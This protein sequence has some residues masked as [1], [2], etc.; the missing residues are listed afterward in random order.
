VTG[1]DDDIV[2]HF[3]VEE[4]GKRHALAAEGPLT[5]CWPLTATVID[6][7]GNE[8]QITINPDGSVQ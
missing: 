2:V 6:Q 3:S 1:A 5:A 7:N 4:D 8:L